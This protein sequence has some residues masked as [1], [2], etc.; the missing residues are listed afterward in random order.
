MA[1]GEVDHV[2][3]IAHAGAVRR[4][5]V[6]APDVERG[7]PADRHLGDVGEE[8]VRH[9]GRVLADTARRMRAGRIEIAQRYEA[10]IGVRARV[11][12]QELFHDELRLAIGIGRPERVRLRNRQLAR[13]AVHRG[14]GAEHHPAHAVLRHRLEQGDG[15]TDVVVVIQQRLL[16]RLAHRLQAGEVHNGFD[17]IGKN[18]FQRRSIPDI[19]LMEG[20]AR[21]G[22][23][24]GYAFQHATLGVR[25][26]VDDGEAV[27]RLGERDA[28]MRADVAEAAGDEY[29][30]F[31][32]LSGMCASHFATSAG[33]E[34]SVSSSARA[35]SSVCSTDCTTPSFAPLRSVAS[36]RRVPNGSRKYADQKRPPR[37]TGPTT[38]TP[39]DFT[40]SIAAS[41]FSGGTWKATCCMPPTWSRTC[42]GS[43]LGYSKMANSESLPM[44]KK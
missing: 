14:R 37:G 24:F 36:S 3:V 6:R 19:R 32:F 28:G 33:S 1:F 39:Q 27:A 8:V 25:Q 43:P 20:D 22:C 26:V 16:H 41:N 17:R 13:L 29:G 42:F 31:Q 40:C 11:V 5:V 38:C 12:V 35:S 9:A 15:A 10:E 18:L 4:G 30:F 2:D 34:N 23:Q 44:S 21:P 7:T